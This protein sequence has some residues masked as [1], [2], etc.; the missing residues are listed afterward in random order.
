MYNLN[1]P[2][3]NTYVGLKSSIPN[4]SEDA[5]TTSKTRAF[6]I[7]SL[8]FITVNFNFILIHLYTSQF[9]QIVTLKF[10]FDPIYTFYKYFFLSS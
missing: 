5:N 3:K 8:S 7:F 4:D 2:L 6:V 9:L 1:N 10:N